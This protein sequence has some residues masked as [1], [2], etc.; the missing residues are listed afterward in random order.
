MAVLNITPDSFSDGGRLLTTDEIVGHARRLL[1]EGA[2][3]LDVGGESTRPGAAPV[4]ADE[5]RARV[6]PAIAAI[7]SALPDVPISIDTYKAQVA[8]AAI[9][10]GADVINDIWGLTHGLGSSERARW[11]E[12]ARRDADVAPGSAA[13]DLPAM[14]TTA[15]RLRCPV[16]A[17]HNRPDR[18]YGDFWAD[19]L[20]DLRLSLTLASRAGI[21]SHQIWLDPGFGFAKS[22]PQ[23]LEVITRLSRIVGLGHPVL[24]GTSRKSTLGVVLDG[25]PVDDRL[26]ATAATAVW[27]IQ[28]GCAMIRVHEV[29]PLRRFV[30]TA[31]AVKAGLAFSPR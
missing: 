5:E 14:A 29:A 17:M 12:I 26:E 16:I 21:A 9:R 22:P 3:M 30:R 27:A 7:R 6:L 23:N 18:N 31:D 19:V 11:R 13:P 1:A 2:D 10:A 8:E 4:S 25:A 15:A 24:V 20:L 28:Q